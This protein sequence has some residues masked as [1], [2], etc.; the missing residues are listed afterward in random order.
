ARQRANG[1]HLFRPVELDQSHAIVDVDVDVNLDL[2]RHFR[3]ASSGLTERF[4]VQVVQL[5]GA[6]EH[7]SERIRRCESEERSSQ[8]RRW[9]AW[10]PK[11]R[12]GSLETSLSYLPLNTAFRFS[13]K[14]RIPSFWSSVR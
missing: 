14:A 9:A 11:I 13:R 8:R 1:V 2:G 4:G 3:D 12:S 10:A 7:R 6:S 5:L